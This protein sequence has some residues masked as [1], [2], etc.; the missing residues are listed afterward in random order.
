[1]SREGE[2]NSDRS[3]S[4]RPERQMGALAVI[5][6]TELLISI[7]CAADGSVNRGMMMTS[8][9]YFNRNILAIMGISQ[10]REIMEDCSTIR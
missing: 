2:E 3:E 10:R 4:Q 1:M 7:R 6:D 5:A 8:L 9:T